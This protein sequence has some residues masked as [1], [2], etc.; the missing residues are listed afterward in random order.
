V[1]RGDVQDDGL[2]QDVLSLRGYVG[3]VRLALDNLYLRK[4]VSA[5]GG[6][7]EKATA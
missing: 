1:L 5:A 7:D 2:L 4:V 6:T 3:R